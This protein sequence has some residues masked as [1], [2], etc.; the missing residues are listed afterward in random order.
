[1]S[2]PRLSATEYKKQYL[3]SLQNDISNINKNYQANSVFK[4][5]GQPAA[6]PDTRSITEKMADLEG[7]KVLLRAELAKITD[8]ANASSIVGQL[9]PAE[10]EFA[11][12]QFGAIEKELKSRFKSGVPAEAFLAF[13]DKFIRQYEETAGV[14]PT[15]DE[16]LEPI[17]QEL[18]L[19]T[20]RG[21]KANEGAQGNYNSQFTGPLPP[22][23]WSGLRAAEVINAWKRMKLEL[24]RQYAEVGD[25]TQIQ[26]DRRSQ[27]KSNIDNAR[28][29]TNSSNIKKWCENNPA[30][31]KLLRDIVSGIQ[32]AGIMGG[33]LGMVL[34]VK[35]K[36]KGM[37]KNDLV[38][39]GRYLIDACK[40]DEDVIHI[41]K[42]CGTNVPEI[43]TRKVSRFVGNIV[44][45]IVG[46]K[47]PQYEDIEPLTDD[48]RGYLYNLVRKSK[49]NNIV[50]IPQPDKAKQQL[51]MDRWDLLKGEI[52]AGNDNAEL[53]KEFKVLLLK[54]TKE[55]RI[56]KREANEVLY[57]LMVLGK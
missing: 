17:K 28:L 50:K 39:F 21:N 33:S 37:K 51:E 13:L 5:T 14:A 42:P 30:D 43:P 56:P 35:K 11:Y 9:Q 41:K 44:K 52:L 26:L 6:P 2:Q 7:V 55:G 4:I 12:K 24:F 8:G 49:L 15:F 3:A 16:A 40:L 36:P 25:L 45:G 53:I 1:M 27:L 18:Q 31:W 22:E 32:G 38:D 46:G 34:P 23:D 57:D 19:L 10:L 20:K 48:E 54:Y 47:I 29:G